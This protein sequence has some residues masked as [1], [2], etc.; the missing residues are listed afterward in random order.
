MAFAAYAS[1]YLTKHSSDTVSSS[2]PLFFSF[3][4]DDADGHRHHEMDLDDMDD[5]HLQDEG[6]TEGESIHGHLNEQDDDPYLKLDESPPGWL[7]HLSHSPRPA[8]SRTRSSSP[9]SSASDAPP[10][11]LL[12]ARTKPPKQP[13]PPSQ[14]SARG[15]AR[16]PSPGPN[17]LTDSLL[18][19]AGLDAFSLPDPRHSRG[20]RRHHN[21]ALWTSLWLASASGAVVLCIVLLLSTRRPKG[22]PAAFL[23]Y[24]ILLRTVPVLTLLTL[25][26]AG[27][28][29]AHV[30]LLRVF[31]GPVMWGTSVFVPA[32]LAVSAVW[33]FVGSFM[34]EEGVE[35]TWGETVGY[36]LLFQM[37]TVMTFK[38]SV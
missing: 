34:W 1:Q 26:S 28:A 32:T 36:V 9:S 8:Q 16:S 38:F 37:L 22:F 23:P 24:A 13:K 6:D 12:S 35:P 3:T 7:A 33:A 31:A 18:P 29:Y 20:R 15:R 4:T 17:Q 5:P 25:L 21:D 11:E 19:R 27:A 30:W 2:Q 14:R 10:P